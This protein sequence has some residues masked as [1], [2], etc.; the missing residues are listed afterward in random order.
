MNLGVSISCRARLVSYQL[1]AISSR[2]R[3]LRAEETLDKTAL[4]L[5]GP[6]LPM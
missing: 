6:H 3:E 5:Q 1:P 2:V 4:L